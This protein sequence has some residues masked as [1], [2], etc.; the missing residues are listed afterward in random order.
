M[1]KALVFLLV[2][3]MLVPL[4]AGGSKEDD[5]TIRIG[6]FEPASGD[7]GAGGKQETLGIEYWYSLQCG[8]HQ[9]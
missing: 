2:L 1:K 5:N 6:V 7:N 4:F 9:G 8:A 3:A